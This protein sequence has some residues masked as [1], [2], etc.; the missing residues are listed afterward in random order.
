MLVG[1]QSEKNICSTLEISQVSSPEHSP[2]FDSENH[3]RTLFPQATNAGS[4]RIKED[5][6][7]V[8]TK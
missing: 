7:S 8:S 1:V 6:T 2:F 4:Y 3:S 5:G